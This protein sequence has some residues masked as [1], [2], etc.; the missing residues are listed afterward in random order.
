[1]SCSSRRLDE[2]RHTKKSEYIIY[3]LKVAP[4]LTFLSLHALQPTLDF[5]VD[6]FEV[7]D[8]TNRNSKARDIMTD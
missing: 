7:D 5:L 4:T 2:T 8:W 1:M 3:V 6:L